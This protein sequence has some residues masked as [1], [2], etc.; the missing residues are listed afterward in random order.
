MYLVTKA[1]VLRDVKYKEADKIL[2]LFSDKEGKITARAYGAMGSKSKLAA[3]SQPLS[4]S[5]YTLEYRNNKHAV[6]E[7]SVIEP[8]LMLRKDL[9]LFS[10][11]CYFAECIDSFSLE[12]TQ[13]ENLIRLLLNSLYA[14]N[15]SLYPASQIKACF[16][17]KLISLSGYAPDMDECCSCGSEI[18]VDPVF[19][20]EIGRICCR[21]CYSAEY[22]P[23]IPV[24]SSVISA[25]KH[26]LSHG[27]KSFLSF[28]IPD[29]ELDA[30]EH[31]CETYFLHHSGRTYSTLNYWKSIKT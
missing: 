25:L 4:Y 12:G 11:G 31:I 29:Q 7:A 26:I 1:V 3:A 18:P 27:L 16:E 14:L 21:S 10:L 9:S 6:K 2:T 24:S 17:L 22:G 8:F 28:K 30:L 13:D 19:C 23:C 15:Y 5:E 20:C